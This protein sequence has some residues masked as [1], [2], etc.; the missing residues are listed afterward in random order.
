MA[1]TEVVGVPTKAVEFYRYTKEFSIAIPLP[2]SQ[3]A[4]NNV[5]NILSTRNLKDGD[6]L[7]FPIAGV[8]DIDGA[9]VD[10]GCLVVD[11]V[12]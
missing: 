9:R 6:I 8:S 7:I 4:P 1:W 3:L 10:D 2:D 11:V 5:L 12:D